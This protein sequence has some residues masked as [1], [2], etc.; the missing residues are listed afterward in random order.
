MS[1]YAPVFDRLA[2]AREGALVP[3]VMVGDPSIDDSLAIIDA[4]I[5]GGADALELGIPFSDPV[6]DG[7][8]IQRSH[9]RG[10]ASQVTME[11]CFEALERLRTKHPDIPV[12][13]LVYANVPFS[14]G[15]RHFY[16][17]CR[18]V[19]VDS[20]LI[21]DVP[22]RES[23]QIVTAAREAGVD[24]VFIAPPSANAQTLKQ[25]ADLSEGYIYAVSRVGVTGVEHE[26]GTETLDTA[27]DVIRSHT[28]TPVLLG[29][30]I[31]RP[32][33]VR[34]AVDHG[35]DGAITGS[36]TV[37]IIEKYCVADP[38]DTEEEEYR[39]RI[40]DRDGLARELTAFIKSMKQA[41]M[42]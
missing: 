26:A 27:I 33:H 23:A 30:G 19:G 9:L 38:G 12:G 4:L 15:T 31:S 3:F 11:T 42:K 18:E 29:F 7:P 22:T 8:T 13:L 34:A 24:S 14:M 17:R 2:Q 37:A 41:T 25:V 5:E 40:D 10:L 39:C 28:S 16:Q 6:A 36:A 21:P 35:A 1:R 20:V 32:D